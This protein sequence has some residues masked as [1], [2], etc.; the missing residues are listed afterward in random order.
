M[1]LF[2]QDRCFLLGWQLIW[3][4]EHV[5][6]VKHIKKTFYTI[7]YRS[8][9]SDEWPVISPT[10]QELSHLDDGWV[11]DHSAYWAW[12]QVKIPKLFRYLSHIQRAAT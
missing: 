5:L 12:A 4:I 10:D 11:T 9:I 1:F 7:I 3:L 8:I 6:R 2:G